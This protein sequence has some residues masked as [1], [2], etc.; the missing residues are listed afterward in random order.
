MREIVLDTETTGFD[1]SDGHRIVEI[2]CVELSNHV[3]TGAVW[4]SYVN[5][6]RD[7]PDG[8]FQVHG[9]SETF[10]ADHPVFA[11]IVADF[12]DFLGDS[13]LVIHNAAFDLGFIN[14]EFAMLGIAPIAP[15]RAIDT[16]QMARTRFPGAQASLDALCRR[17]NIDNSARTRH[18][19]L[20]DA[21]LLAEVYLELLGGR[22]HDFTL[23]SENDTAKPD[24]VADPRPTRTPRPHAVS[25]AEQAAHAAFLEQLTDPIW[26]T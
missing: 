9:L 15:A 18:G 13:K 8:A 6:E 11:E 22:Q 4:Q 7:M 23:V 1:P 17:F 25:A 10:L 14:A 20:L 3:P 2:G 24:P 21:E 16:V 19:A 12:I 5:P 26:K